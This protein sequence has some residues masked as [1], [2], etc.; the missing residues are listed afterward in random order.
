MNK[1]TNKKVRYLG[2][3]VMVAQVTDGHS[4]ILLKREECLCLCISLYVFTHVCAGVRVCMSAC[5]HMETRGQLQMSFFKG[6]CL[7][8]SIS[9]KRYH[10][11]GNSYKGK[12]LIG[13]LHFQRFSPL[14]SWWNMVACRQTW[15]WSRI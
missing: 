7:K 9:V 5:T 1:Q 10:D 12:H 2:L 3:S 8:V 15:C 6:H 14:S 13:D 4:K 11:H